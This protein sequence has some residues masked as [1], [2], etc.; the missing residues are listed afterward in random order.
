MM[1][2]PPGPEP[3]RGDT[4]GLRVAHPTAVARRPHAAAG[5]SPEPAAFE[6]LRLEDLVR[7]VRRAL[8]GLPER[9]ALI[10]AMRFGI[11]PDDDEEH[12]LQEVAEEVGVS[13]ER[14]RQ[15]E[16]EGLQE[17]RWRLRRAV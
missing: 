4:G 17:L 15:L 5:R 2:L 3:S 10:L 1:R 12:T 14:V 16:R 13:K 8:L 11:G 6:G 9:T 7:L